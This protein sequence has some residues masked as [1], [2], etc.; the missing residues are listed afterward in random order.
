VAQVD[1]VK[2]LVTQQK[3]PK[4]TIHTHVKRQKCPFLLLPPKT[5]LELNVKADTPQSFSNPTT[6]RRSRSNR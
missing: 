3:P 2:D 4:M 6:S 1:W 5:S